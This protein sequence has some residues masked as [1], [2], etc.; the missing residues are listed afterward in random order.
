MFSA[1]LLEK[2]VNFDSFTMADCVGVD[3]FS[4]AGV[5]HS[6]FDAALAIVRLRCSWVWSSHDGASGDAASRC[7]GG[8][9]I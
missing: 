6:A 4:S 8:F 5:G 1:R 2:D 9:W 3:F 7:V